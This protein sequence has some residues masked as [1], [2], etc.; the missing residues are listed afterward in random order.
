MP[1]FPNNPLNRSS[2][3]SLNSMLRKYPALFGMPFVLIVGASFA[4]TPFTRTRYDLQ[5]QRNSSVSKEDELGLNQRKKKFDIREEYYRI[6]S[7]ADQEWVPKRIERPNGVPDWGV[8]P[9]EPPSE[10]Q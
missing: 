4:M 3:S 10:R 2:D 8:P 9:A 6:Q 7:V 1:A 5:N